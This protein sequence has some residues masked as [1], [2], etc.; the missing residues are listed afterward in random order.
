MWRFAVL[1]VCVALTGCFPAG[2]R[3]AESV[4]AIYD[5]GLSPVPLLAE[6]SVG[7]ALEVHAPPWLDAVGIDYRLAY[8]D[9]AQ[10]H[11]YAH[12]RWVG[13]PAQLIQ[14]RLR[15][16]L[17]LSGQGQ[18][19]ASCS[20]R[21]EISE[22]GQIFATPESSK[23]LLLGRA[24][25]LD[26]SRHPVAELNLEIEKPAPTPDSSGGIKALQATVDQLSLD[27]LAWEKR[28]RQSGKIS[29]CSS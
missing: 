8:R 27:L 26:R 3:G 24:Y 12:A 9:A 5:L 29:G 2:R 1:A 17:S 21:L 19:R 4:P 28:L 6:R 16:S 11:E 15:Q 7:L 14:Q 18:T 13:P 25:W 22:F 10:R 20:I 23:G